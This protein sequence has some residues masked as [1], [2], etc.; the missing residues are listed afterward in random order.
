[1]LS[2]VKSL[3]TLATLTLVLA[4]LM[5]FV[6]DELTLTTASFSAAF[7]LL[8]AFWVVAIVKDGLRIYAPASAKWLV[9]FQFSV[10]S[11]ALV[12]ALYGTPWT[13]WFR[14]AVPFLFLLAFFPFV[15]VA[16]REPQSLI[17]AVHI[18]SVLWLAKVA[19]MSGA[20]IAAVLAGE[21]QRLTQATEDWGTLTLPFGFIG[22]IC[23]LFNNAPFARRLRWLLAPAFTLVA[24]LTVYRSQL[25]IVTA[26]WMVYLVGLGARRML[27]ITVTLCALAAA[28][29]PYLLGLGL[30]QN[31]AERF[32]EVAGELGGSRMAEIRFA[33]RNFLESPLFGKGLGYPVPAEVTFFGD[34]Q[35]MR[36]AGVDS[37]GYVHN[38]VAYMAMDL[39]L[40]GLVC[41]FG[42][43]FGNRWWRRRPTDLRLSSL[44]VIAVLGLGT[45]LAWILVE[46]SFR[47]IQS[48][49]A[50]AALIAVLAALPAIPRRSAIAP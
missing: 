26:V 50:L 41:F 6:P 9:G 11:S 32:S 28:S 13:A 4:A 16:K 12:A 38:A 43:I 20:G 40:I 24:L 21:A 42:F 18:A 10:L 36:E 5:P 30:I 1:L 22:L 35:A 45:L 27:G 34:V 3:P 44:W 39:G 14:G 7:V 8:F 49:L 37:V 15:D 48:N 33:F 31:I 23:S 2:K 19:V 29:M 47:Q 17:N 46:A 25:L